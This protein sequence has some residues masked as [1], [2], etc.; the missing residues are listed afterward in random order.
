MSMYWNVWLM[1]VTVTETCSELYS[2]EY[3]VVFWMNILVSTQTQAEGLT[4]QGALLQK[5]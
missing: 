2:I 3:A 1:M 5:E 4:L